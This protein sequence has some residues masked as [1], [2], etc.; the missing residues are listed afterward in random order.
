MPEQARRLSSCFQWIFQISFRCLSG[1]IIGEGVVCKPSQHRR[2]LPVIRA[3][4][5][6]DGYIRIAVVIATR[7]GA[8][9]ENSPSPKPVLSHSS[10]RRGPISLPF[11]RAQPCVKRAL[12]VTNPFP[13]HTPANVAR[14]SRRW[15]DG[16]SSRRMRLH[17]PYRPARSRPS[18]SANLKST[19]TAVMANDVSSE[20]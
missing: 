2:Q 16:G 9:R 5:K 8:V 12:I 18:A 11:G 4:L 19:T 14:P 6:D 3:A 7:S 1:H 13:S 10:S 20:R 15:L 17:Y